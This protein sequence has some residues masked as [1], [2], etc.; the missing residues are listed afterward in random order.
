MAPTGTLLQTGVGRLAAACLLVLLVFVVYFPV[1]RAGYIWDD[2]QYVSQ[3]ATLTD[4]KGL[5]RIWLEPQASPQ[6]YPLVFT[7]FW[8][9]HHIAG[10]DAR[11]NHLVN[12]A[13]HAL[14]AVMLWLVLRQ[15]QVP[16]AW[17]VA[18]VFGVHPVHVES[19][20]W[21]TE[22]KNVL[23]MLF[24]LASA[25][26][27][28][29]F[30]LVESTTS[31][32]GARDGIRVSVLALTLFLCAL[33]SKTMT[34][35]LPVA[36]LLVVW[37]K[38]GTVT[39]R[40]L[41]PLV[42][43]FALGVV[44]GAL[45]AWLEVHHVGAEGED[46]SL[47]PAARV[48][49]AGRAV[50][51]YA[52]K[53]VWPHPLVFVYPQ[54]RLD[55]ANWLQ[56][57]FPLSVA[58]VMVALWTLRS[59]MGRGPFVAAAYFV[60]ALFPALGF[61]NVYPMRY[62]YVADH[63]QYLASIGLLALMTAAAVGLVRRYGRPVQVGAGAVVIA[64]LAL[65]SRGEA[66]KYEDS[67]ALWQDTLAKN[68]ACW[69]AY[70]NLGN[71]RTSQGRLTEARASFEA[72]LRIKPNVAI[73]YNNIGITWFR[74]GRLTEATE[75]H[76]TA[77]R[78]DPNY[79]EAHNNLGV[80]FAN[81]QRYGDAVREYSRALALDPAYAMAH[82]NLANVLVRMKRLPEADDHYRRAVQL[83]PTMA[84]AYYN[85]GVNLLVEGRPQDAAVNLD[86]AFRLQPDFFIG[87]YEVGNIHLRAGRM[88][89]AIEQYRQAIAIKPDYADAYAHLGAALE[90]A[91]QVEDAVACYRHLL[92]LDPVNL[93]ARTGLER[94]IKRR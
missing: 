61:F 52:A 50:W 64:V 22:R 46:W 66:A 7:T 82:Y 42:P 58:A 78:L 54:W 40:E 73:F 21:V 88:A 89:Q 68:P 32:T 4:L 33:L 57:L 60:S 72:A 87:H 49:L 8:I 28:L 31:P 14:N 6:Y 29:R 80:D 36:L 16:G 2:D 25:L 20:A 10:N 1:M 12:I 30:A 93:Q 71:L 27:Y 45:T 41:V 48:L 44:F 47:P 75:N 23:S 59:R 15:L 39:R 18:A 5:E 24:Y 65:V 43:L 83:R 34:S 38:R 90:Q 77:V 51:F 3:N 56:Y 81:S 55:P 37:W 13:L 19:V 9:E 62:S 74:E 92:E 53:L 17:L 94:L 84:L 76:E 26:A 86:A 63:F 70:N 91:G 67:E 69:M 35:T 11:V 85:L 79:A